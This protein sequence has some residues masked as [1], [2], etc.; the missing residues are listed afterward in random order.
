ML[1]LGRTRL[2]LKRDPPTRVRWV[3]IWRGRGVGARYWYPLPC[4]T[5]PSPSPDPDPRPSP[6]SDPDE[7]YAGSASLSCCSS[8]TSS[9]SKPPPA[10]HPLCALGGRCGASSYYSSTGRSNIA[11][12]R[13][14]AAC[15]PPLHPCSRLKHRLPDCL[16]GAMPLPPRPCRPCRATPALSHGTGTGYAYAYAYA[17]AYICMHI[18]PIARHRSC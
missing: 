14:D 9:P 6:C 7:P 15:T 1:L 10:A 8:T 16:P 17:Y 11:Y 12:M 5:Q 13:C 2:P 4:P 3:G 18:R